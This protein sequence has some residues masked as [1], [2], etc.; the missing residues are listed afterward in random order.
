MKGSMS[1]DLGI[2][3][4]DQD[5]IAKYAGTVAVECFG[6]VGMATV[7]MKDGLV[8]LLKQES[9]TKGIQVNISEDN[10]ITLDFHIIVAYGVSISAVTDNLISNVKYKVEEF[11]GMTVDKI[12]VYIEGVRVID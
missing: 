9:L 2:I 6:I 11:S 10:R 12:N 7:S 1:T 3:T 4:I 5:V 8:K